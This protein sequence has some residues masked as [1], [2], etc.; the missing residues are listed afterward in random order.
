M[1]C[2]IQLFLDTINQ[3][4][5]KFTFHILGGKKIIEKTNWNWS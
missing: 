1:Y 3:K 5:I 2:S 4:N